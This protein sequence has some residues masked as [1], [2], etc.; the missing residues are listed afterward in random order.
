M[1]K[2]KKFSILVGWAALNVN[3]A[4]LERKETRKIANIADQLEGN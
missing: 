1:D 4:H 2:Y 3:V